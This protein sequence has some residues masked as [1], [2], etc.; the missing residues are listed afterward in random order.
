[1]VYK[2]YYKIQYV[3][4]NGEVMN[5]I[6]KVSY[7]Y[8]SLEK[9]I[10]QNEILLRT[11][12]F[13]ELQKYIDDKSIKFLDRTA[14]HYFN[15]KN[16]LKKILFC[17]IFYKKRVKTKDIKEFILIKEYKEECEKTIEEIKDRL[18]Y[19]DFLS[20]IKDSGVSLRL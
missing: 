5:E 12:D 20:L 11:T 6:G 13:N 4:K 2:N 15:K 17:Y 14:H 8:T 18:P 1:M 16:E 10:L 7:S 9:N 19:N 3:L